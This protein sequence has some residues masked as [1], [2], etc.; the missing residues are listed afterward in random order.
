MD[1]DADFTL[2]I[3]ANKTVALTFNN[4]AL[5]G[6]N[7]TIDKCGVKRDE[8]GIKE[9]LNTIML[10]VEASINEFVAKTAPQLPEFNSFNYTVEFDYQDGAIGIG[11]LIT[12]K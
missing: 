3:L 12:P 2:Q 4:L 11:A 10:A 8:E 5:T 9:R 7:V 1:I 6:F